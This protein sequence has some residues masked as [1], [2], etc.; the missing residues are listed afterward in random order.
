MRVG[1]TGIVMGGGGKEE[2]EN[3]VEGGLAERG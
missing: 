1:G 2:R 3:V